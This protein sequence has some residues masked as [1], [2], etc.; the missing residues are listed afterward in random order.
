MLLGIRVLSTPC[1]SL[2][3]FMCVHMVCWYACMYF[4]MWMAMYTYKILK[5]HTYYEIV[6]LSPFVA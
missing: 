5:C 4:S 1:I 2:C 6:T 3:V